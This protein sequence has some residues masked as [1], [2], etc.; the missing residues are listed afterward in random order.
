MER[1]SRWREVSKAL[2]TVVISFLMNHLG[3]TFKFGTRRV[4]KRDRSGRIERIRDKTN[5]GRLDSKRAA[6]AKKG[7]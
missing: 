7:E 1:A 5:Q 2:Q 4:Y 6:V 3:N